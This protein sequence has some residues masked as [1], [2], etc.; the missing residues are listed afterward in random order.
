LCRFGGRGGHRLLGA[1]EVG[2]P[3]PDRGDVDGQGEQRDPG[4][5]QEPAGEPGGEG[6]AVDRYWARSSGKAPTRLPGQRDLARPRIDASGLLFVSV[7][8]RRFVY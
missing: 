8:A 4:G 5:N 1:G 2:A 7:P 3:D 6:M